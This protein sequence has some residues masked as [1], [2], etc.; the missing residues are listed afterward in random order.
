MVGVWGFRVWGFGV[1]GV[2]CIVEGLGCRVLGFRVS[3]AF[4]VA[5][6]GFRV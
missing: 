4:R 1:E 2:G 3:L 6:F 5:I